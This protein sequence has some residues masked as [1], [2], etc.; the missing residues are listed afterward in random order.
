MKTH[1]FTSSLHFNVVQA[2]PVLGEAESDSFEEYYP[3]ED[4]FMS[5]ANYMA[6]TTVTDFCKMWEATGN[7]NE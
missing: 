3:F 4:L 6:K 5:S 1:K 7:D 2:D